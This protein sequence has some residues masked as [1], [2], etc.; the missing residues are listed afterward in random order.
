M[1]ELVINLISHGFILI[2]TTV[3]IILSY[4]LSHKYF[5]SIFF[6]SCIIVILLSYYYKLFII[7]I[8]TSCIFISYLLFFLHKHSHTLFAYV[9]SKNQGSI[10]TDR[11]ILDQIEEAV[12]ELS[13][14]KTGAIITFEKGENLDSFIEQGKKVHAPLTSEML[15][16]IF[17]DGTPLHDGAVIVRDNY[18]EAAAVFY[19]PT[20]KAMPGKCGAR[21]RAALG[22]SEEHGSITVVVSEE[23]GK[24]SLAINGELIKL[25][26]DTFKVKFEECIK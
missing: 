24:V 11:S 23:T 25:T 20:T 21:H 13:L 5:S 16:T 18:I 1:N 3:I 2:V 22:F 12:F 15:R 9:N 14:S 4:K 19:T 6:G 10:H 7:T 8:I 17:Y 26:R